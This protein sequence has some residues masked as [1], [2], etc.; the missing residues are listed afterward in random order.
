[1]IRTALVQQMQIEETAI[2]TAKTELEQALAS[3]SDMGNLITNL[4]L[5]NKKFKD[6]MKHV[7][8]H[9]PKAKAKARSGWTRA[10]TVLGHPRCAG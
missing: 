3:D 4:E 9:L 7:S 1:M 10:E 5:A 6:Q 8:M 2:K